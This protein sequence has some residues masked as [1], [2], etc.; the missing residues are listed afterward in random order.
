[1]I[2]AWFYGITP[3]PPYI[4]SSF[5][6]PF[7]VFLRRR[8]PPECGICM[9]QISRSRFSSFPL[10]SASSPAPSWPSPSPSPPP[11]FVFVSLSNVLL[12]FL[13]AGTSSGHREAPPRH[14][15]I[16]HDRTE[17]QLIP[18]GHPHSG[19]KSV[20]S[21]L[22]ASGRDAFA[23]SARCSTRYYFYCGVIDARFGHESPRVMDCR[24]RA[25]TRV[26]LCLARSLTGGG[27]QSR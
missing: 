25:K 26:L 21:A 8:R 10:R 11:S 4:L 1:M 15:Q 24:S 13:V 22:S 12:P 2:L 20:E 6:S 16:N 9:S 18:G 17:S 5:I 14:T 27:S 23:L 3:I 19:G 7:H